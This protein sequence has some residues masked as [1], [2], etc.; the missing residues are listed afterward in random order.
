M[1]QENVLV[2]DAGDAFLSNFGNSG[3]ANELY[4]RNERLFMDATAFSDG[5]PPKTSALDV[6]AYGWFVY[7]VCNRSFL[8]HALN[9]CSGVY[10]HFASAH[11]E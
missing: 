11:C 7:Q 6:Y 2:S 3:T 8:K 1:F 5:M 10:G 9:Q 4:L